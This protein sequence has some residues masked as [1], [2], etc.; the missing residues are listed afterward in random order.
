MTNKD[1]L[2]ALELTQKELCKTVEGIKTNDLPHLAIAVEEVR[3]TA[4]SAK[5]RAGVTLAGL[6]FI[7][8]MISVLGIIIAVAVV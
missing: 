6:G 5:F 4:K 8:L 7:A 3:V 1:R 2:M